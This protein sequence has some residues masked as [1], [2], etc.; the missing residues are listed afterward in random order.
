MIDDDLDV[1]AEIKHSGEIR[2]EVVGVLLL[3]D[4]KLCD[5]PNTP[6]KSTTGKGQFKTSAASKLPKLN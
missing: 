2:D 6:E 5:K 4:E 3:I 1:L